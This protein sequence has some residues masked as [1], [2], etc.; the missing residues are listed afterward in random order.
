M[1]KTGG[2]WAE[3]GWSGK[4]AAG[5]CS[6]DCASGDKLQVLTQMLLFSAQHGMNWIN[7]GLMPGDIDRSGDE[8][9]LNRVGGWIGAMA[10]KD[11]TNGG[12]YPC[13]LKTAE[14]LGSHVAQT[15]KR[16]DFSDQLQSQSA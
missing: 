5:F 14:H 8:N 16:H 4:M 2:I 11:K 9:N 10:Q 6:S 12:L 7:L 15:I 1:E 13:D 3:Q